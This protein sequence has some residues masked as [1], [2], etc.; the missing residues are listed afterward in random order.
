MMLGLGYT[1]AATAPFVLG[2]IRDATGSFQGPLWVAV[3]CIVVL[4]VLVRL[5]GRARRA[6]IRA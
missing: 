3:G 6:P 1:L 4:L 2:A 5:L